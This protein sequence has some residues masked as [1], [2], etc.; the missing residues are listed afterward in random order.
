MANA[1]GVDGVTLAFKLGLDVPSVTLAIVEDRMELVAGLGDEV[2]GRLVDESN[3]K[4][5]VETS[6]WL[7]D[8]D[9]LIGEP[10]VKELDKLLKKLPDV[11]KLDIDVSEASVDEKLGD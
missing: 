10:D 8:A 5:L 6:V 2:L 7:D 9:L 11:G 3:D 1:E 4:E